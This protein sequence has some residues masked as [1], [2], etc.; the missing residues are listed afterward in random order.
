MTTEQHK[1]YEN[2]MMGAK[3]Y[4]EDADELEEVAVASRSKAKALRESAEKIKQQAADE[5]AAL[6]GGLKELNHD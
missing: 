2:A 3:F 6:E 5:L 4:D 1:Q